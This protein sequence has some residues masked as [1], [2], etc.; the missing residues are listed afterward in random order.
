ME[1]TKAEL[2]KFKKVQVTDEELERA[3]NYR[4]GVFI[5]NNLTTNENVA[6]AL[7]QYS[8][9]GL[10]LNTINEYPAKI[11]AVQKA[12]IVRVANKYIFP[13]KLNIIIVKPKP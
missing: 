7:V 13:D 1:L 6:D 8:L 2:E 5:S 3:K 12:D 10:D 4:S 9:F 11:Q